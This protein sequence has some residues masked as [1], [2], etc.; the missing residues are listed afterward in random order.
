M[1]FSD[2][3]K[4]S[5][6]ST[7][8]KYKKILTR[9]STCISLIC[10]LPAKD[11]MPHNA[12]ANGAERDLL[13]TFFLFRFCHDLRGGCKSQK[14]QLEKVNVLIERAPVCK[15]IFVRGIPE[16]TP[17]EEIENYFDKFGIVEKFVTNEEEVKATRVNER[18]AI[19]YFKTDNST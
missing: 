19:V 15:S 12:T 11:K 8:L 18:I 13:F 7:V 4:C 5:C 2:E 1:R 16:N 3:V 6:N 17:L 10:C 9:R 14:K